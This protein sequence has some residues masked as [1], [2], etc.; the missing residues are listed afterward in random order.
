VPLVFVPRYRSVPLLALDFEA[1]E[2]R[3][4]DAIGDVVV[5]VESERPMEPQ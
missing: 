3:A 2:L 1:A 5:R 4:L